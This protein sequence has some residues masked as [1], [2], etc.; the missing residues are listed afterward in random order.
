MRYQVVAGIKNDRTVD[1]SV[2]EQLVNSF[3]F[4]T[5]SSESSWEYS[6]I[7]SM[8]P[9]N[10]TAKMNMFVGSYGPFESGSMF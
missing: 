1:L 2:A 3:Y 4:M 6:Q 7:I 10:Y 5:S 8:M 9:V